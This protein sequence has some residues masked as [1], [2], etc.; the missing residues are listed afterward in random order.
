MTV[1]AIKAP[2]TADRQQIIEDPDPFGAN[3]HPDLLVIP[4]HGLQLGKQLLRPLYAVPNHSDQFGSGD[5]AEIPDYG[6]VTFPSVFLEKGM[7]REGE[8]GARFKM[9]QQNVSYLM[10]ENDDQKSIRSVYIQPDHRTAVP[11]GGRM[12][13]SRIFYEPYPEFLTP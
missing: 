5:E 4:K 7:N 8:V 3:L 2:A 12:S 1:A 11:V 9:P 13:R 10:A 6:C